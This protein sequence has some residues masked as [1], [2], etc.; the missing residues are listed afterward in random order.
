V[1]CSA[2]HSSQLPARCT[3]HTRYERFGTTTTVCIPQPI[4]RDGIARQHAHNRGTEG[5]QNG[6]I[7]IPPMAIQS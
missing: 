2:W 4:H 6:Q 7:R 3:E 1:F 5:A